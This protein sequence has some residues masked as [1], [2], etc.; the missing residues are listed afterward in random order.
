MIKAGAGRPRI[1]HFLFSSSLISFVLLFSACGEKP[2]SNVEYG[3]KNGILFISN[4]EEP[5]GLDPQ[6]TTGDPDRNVILGL[7]EG[8]VRLNPK[9]L[10]PEPG[11]AE[12]WTISE[13]GTTYVFNIRENARWSNGDPMTAHELVWTYTRALTP[14]MP[15]E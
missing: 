12:S 9:T 1:F 13:D 7:F 8:L 10:H 5:K 3:N 2:L 14:T 6:L 15:N 11:V 4:G